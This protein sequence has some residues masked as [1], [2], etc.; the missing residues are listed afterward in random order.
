MALR[1]VFFLEQD[2]YVE[3][4]EELYDMEARGQPDQPL[5]NARLPWLPHPELRETVPNI[6]IY[7]CLYQLPHQLK[8]EGV[9]DK[10]SDLD[11]QLAAAVEFFN[12]CVPNQ[13]G[14][15]S[16]VAAV[17]LLPEP[18]RV[19]LAWKK[20][21]FCGKRL[22]K[23]RYIRSLIQSHVEKQQ[24]DEEELILVDEEQ[25]NQINVVI[26]TP[27]YSDREA[28]SHETTGLELIKMEE[29]NNSNPLAPLATNVDTPLPSHPLLDALLLNDPR[30]TQEESPASAAR[31]NAGNQQSNDEAKDLPNPSSAVLSME[32]SIETEFCSDSSHKRMGGDGISALPVDKKATFTYANFDSHQFAQSIGFDEET[33]LGNL[34]SDIEIEQLSVY[35][36]EY[37]QRYAQLHVESFFLLLF[38]EK[39]GMA[40]QFFKC[41][42]VWMWRKIVAVCQS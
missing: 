39:L 29:S 13:P 24:R 35:A 28:I 7:S 15:S 33:K 40:L 31:P 3:R 36:R 9:S 37:A 19:A 10:A 12:L 4:L 14:F 17:T 38:S 11:K 34:V 42:S 18:S 20:W 32:K 5:Y 30:T 27:S 6:S 8:T 16:S 41:V 21:Y 26:H 23:L 1:R 22:R 2:H 25:D